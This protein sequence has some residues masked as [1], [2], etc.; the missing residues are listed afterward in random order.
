MIRSGQLYLRNVLQSLKRPQSVMETKRASFF[1]YM[2]GH[3][4][5]IVKG[6]CPV[7]MLCKSLSPLHCI[8]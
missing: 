1:V 6:A 4:I 3:M 5:I 2:Q 8:L 7:G